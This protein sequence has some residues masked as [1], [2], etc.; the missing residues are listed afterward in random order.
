MQYSA[1]RFQTL[2]FVSL[3]L[4]LCVTFA[5]PAFA[6]RRSRSNGAASAARR[7]STIKAAQAQYAAAQSVLSAAQATGAGAEA[8]LRSVI[9]E[10]NGAAME[11]R[12][13]RSASHEILQDQAEIEEDILAEQTAKTPYYQ[14]TEEIRATKEHL[15]ATEKKLTESADFI[16][17]YDQVR[18][19]DGAQAAFRLRQ[20]TLEN[21]TDYLLQKTTL[22]T[23]SEKRDV[24]KR[25]LFHKDKEWLAHQAQLAEA[26]KEE[27]EASIDLYGSAKERAEPKEQIKTAQ[28]AAAAARESM[29]QAQQI[30]SKLGAS[31]TA[32]KPKTSSTTKTKK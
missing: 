20:T 29:A 5:E 8:R 7:A 10:M 17:K 12:K 13:S 4:L 3:S 26:H 2:V 14:I 15:V 24:L 25:E 28:Q 32:T 31:V 30:L 19:N 18:S 16:H 6:A 22:T 9:A 27:R 21:D 11:L 23:L 1:R